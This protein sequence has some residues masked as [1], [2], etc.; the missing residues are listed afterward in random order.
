[1]PDE[2]LFTLAA[3]GELRKPGVL[4]AQVKR[5]LKDPKAQALAENF[6]GQWL[7]LRNVKALT[8]G[9]GLLPRGTS[10]SATAM[11]REAEAFFEYVVQND[12]QHPGLPRRRLHLRQRAAGEALR[13]RRTSRRAS[14]AR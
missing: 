3:K 11:V 8:P 5:M 1:M 4:E 9:Q 10:R 7:K 6:A 12:R 14:S 13:H 2:E